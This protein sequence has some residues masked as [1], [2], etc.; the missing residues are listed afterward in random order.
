MSD[1]KHRRDTWAT[2]HSFYAVMDH[3]FHP[4]IDVCAMPTNSKCQTFIAPPNFESSASEVK[5]ITGRTLAG[6]DAMKTSWAGYGSVAWCNPPYS[7]IMPWMD[8]ASEMTKEGVTTIMLSHH[9]LAT[10][11]FHKHAS[12]VAGLWILTPRINFI[13]PEGIN[14]E[15][16]QRDSLLWIFS[17]VPVRP[18]SESPYQ[19]ATSRFNWLE[20]GLKHINGWKRKE[21]A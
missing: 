1:D 8:R 19:V 14:G 6:V 21:R 7:D 2:P 17:A 11:W 3:L 10:K 9:G 20:Y 4:S 15:G 16:N 12:Q 18:P 5:F 13:A